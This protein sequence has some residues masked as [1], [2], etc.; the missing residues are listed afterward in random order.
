MY[1]SLTLDIVYGAKQE[2]HQYGRFGSI[3]PNLPNQISQIIDLF[4]LGLDICIFL[5]DENNRY[6]PMRVHKRDQIID[7]QSLVLVHGVSETKE[8]PLISLEGIIS[9]GFTHRNNGYNSYLTDEN[10]DGENYDFSWASPTEDKDFCGDKYGLEIH[11]FLS[12]YEPT[13][14]VLNRSETLFHVTQVLPQDITTY[15]MLNQEVTSSERQ[16]RTM[17]YLKR[18]RDAEL[19]FR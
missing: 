7:I 11:A 13:P 14:I 9:N 17:K 10:L 8:D 16:E 2:I 12:P 5:S 3:Y 6:V 1:E 4:D 19:R 15:I 18:L